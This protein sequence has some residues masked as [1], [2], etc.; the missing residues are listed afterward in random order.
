MH[1]TSP[2]ARGYPWLSI[3]YLLELLRKEKNDFLF[4]CILAHKMT[5]GYDVIMKLSNCFTLLIREKL[6]FL[7]IK[8]FF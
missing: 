2:P 8:A 4:P 1:T 3:V 6:F 7:N 5:R